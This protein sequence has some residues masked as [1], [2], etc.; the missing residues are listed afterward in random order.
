MRE[1]RGKLC[2]A[3]EPGEPGVIRRRAQ[4]LERDRARELGIPRGVHAAHAAGT[5]QADDLVATDL[6][7]GCDAEVVVVLGVGRRP[8][9]AD[10]SRDRRATRLA[11][12][13]M[14]DEVGARAACRE[15]GNFAH[16]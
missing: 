4:H 5:E 11:A 13:D 12:V 10:G 2:L 16:R 6:R 8:I 15:Q 7:A 1:L 3:R 14:R 9:G